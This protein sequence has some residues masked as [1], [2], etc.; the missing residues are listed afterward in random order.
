[1]S[2]QITLN[3]PFWPFTLLI[4][5]ALM[6]GAAVVPPRKGQAG[7]LLQRITLPPELQAPAIVDG[8]QLARQRGKVYVRWKVGGGLCNQLDA[9]VNGLA[10]ALALGADAVV[11]PHTSYRDTFNDTGGEASKSMG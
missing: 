10:L 6:I 4:G 5:L 1:M 9:H 2:K 11:L 7:G 8:S 3:V